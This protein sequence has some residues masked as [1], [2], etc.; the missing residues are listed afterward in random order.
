MIRTRKFKIASLLI[1]LIVICSLFTGCA[2]KSV[3]Q[4]ATT[5]TITDQAS[6]SVTIPAQ[7]NKCYYTSPL[8]MILIYSFAPDKMVGWSMQLTD[9]SIS[10]TKLPVQ[11]V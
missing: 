10:N 7:I 11:L 5:Q 2:A 8:G 3:S 6:R 9:K 1:V 4:Q